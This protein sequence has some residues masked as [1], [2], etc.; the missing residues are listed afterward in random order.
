MQRFISALL[1]SAFLI[2]CTQPADQRPCTEE[3]KLCP[4]GSSVGR[5]GPNCE[6]APCPTLVGCTKELKIC[7]DGTGVGRTGP[8][9]EFEP[10]PG[11]GTGCNYD[12]PAK[13]YTL[14]NAE[15]CNLALMTCLVGHEYFVDSCGCGC[16][17][18]SAEPS[19]DY[20]NS[21]Q[22]YIGK[23]ADECSRIRFTCEQGKEYFSD[24]CGC[25]CQ[26]VEKQACD[27]AGPMMTICTMEY[28]PVCGWF[29][30]SIQ[31][32]RYPC[33]QTFSNGCGACQDENVAYWTDGECPT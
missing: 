30:E 21:K 14:R 5:E 22:T 4:D 19:C 17:P 18:P 13:P 1:L 26:T 8:S 31:C 3:A 11:A 2:G 10:C 28:K 9:C 25:G 23:S 32:I 6:F 20:E 29:K 16:K 24:D 27:P 12:D 7:P 33:A 15:E